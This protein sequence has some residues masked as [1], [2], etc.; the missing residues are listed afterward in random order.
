MKRIF[1]GI[2]LLFF[3]S[4][5]CHAM[6]NPWIYCGDDMNCACK[7]AGFNFPLYVKKHTIRAMENMIEVKFP[8]DKKR[9]ITIRKSTQCINGEDKNGFCDISG[10][11]E[12][13]PVNK[14]IYLRKSTP[15]MVKGDKKK[16][17]VINFSAESGYYSAY[18]KQGLKKKDIKYLYKLLEE[19]EASRLDYD[20]EP[21]SIEQLQDSR[22]IDGIAEPIYTQDCFPRTLEKMGV[23]NECFE[24][25]NLGDDT[26]CSTSQIKMI[27]E[28][29]KQGQENDPLNNGTGQFC[30]N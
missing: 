21:L 13:Y 20:K 16:F 24:R 2:C 6:A 27:K 11:Y 19:S 30:A 29:Y 14:I 1:Y 17:Y 25:A 7:K 10:V 4:A 28:Y 18:S 5:C 22:R 9:T 8:L 15:F 3:M 26:F 23:T 12:T